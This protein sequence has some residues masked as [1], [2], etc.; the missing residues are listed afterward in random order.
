M[1]VIFWEVLLNKSCSKKKMN[2]S[3]LSHFVFGGVWGL[4]EVEK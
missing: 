4:Y 1:L 3:C 2:I